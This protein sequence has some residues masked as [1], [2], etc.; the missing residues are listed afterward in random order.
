MMSNHDRPTVLKR[1]L[2]HEETRP[3]AATLAWIDRAAESLE[4]RPDFVRASRCRI[5]ARLNQQSVRNPLLIWKWSAVYW[6]QSPTLHVALVILLAAAAYFN[7]VRL[8]Q[9][10]RSWIPGDFLYPLK[11][12]SESVLL[13]ASLQPDADARLHIGFAQ[14]RLLEAQSLAFENRYQ[15]IPVVVANYDY[16]VTRAVS[17]VEQISHSQQER[18]RGL[19]GELEQVIIGQMG[20]VDL[21][22]GLSPGLAQ[23]QFERIMMISTGGISAAR[24][25]LAPN[26]SELQP[27]PGLPSA[28]WGRAA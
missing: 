8:S 11:T 12:A 21:L 7:V 19:A 26:S 3:D 18:G 10:S 28:K 16:H 17:L 14:R 25:S 20:V 5:Q 6:W 2:L 24:R 22:Y 13:A 27:Q 1:F 23:A 9:A 4:A 15:H